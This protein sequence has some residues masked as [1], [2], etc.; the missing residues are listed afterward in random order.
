[1]E[2]TEGIERS[3]LFLIIIQFVGAFLSLL[4]GATLV[5]H[6]DPL[7]ECVLFAWQEGDSL[8]YGEPHYCD[9]IGYGFILNNVLVIV[10][11]YLTLRQ[12]SN[13]SSLSKHFSMR[14]L[15]SLKIGKRL[16]I[17]HGIVLSIVFIL[18]VFLTVGY[19]SSCDQLEDHITKL[20]NVKLNQDPNL[21]RGETIEERFVED[22]MFWRY[23][24]QVT[25]AFG[26][27]MY[28]IK[29][30]C[31]ALFTD[32][33]IATLLHDNHVKKYSGY[34]GWWYHQDIYSYDA[35]AQAVRTNVLIE[36]SLAGAWMGTFVWLGATIFIFVQKKRIAKQTSLA[37]SG[38]VDTMSTRSDR[39]GSTLQRGSL[40]PGQSPASSIRL[41]GNVY[42]S[43][44]SNASSYNRKDI[45][46]LALG[47]ILDP[48]FYKNN[49]NNNTVKMA[50]SNRRR[51]GSLGHLQMQ[52]Q[53]QPLLINNRP[54]AGR[55]QYETEI[56]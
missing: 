29:A 11:A 36:A 55:E 46:E 7:S 51:S 15:K 21:L 23:A 2:N 24:Q 8:S 27:N 53:S 54:T 22:P 33:D 17:L 16:I 49:R 25:N 1:M 52:I 9:I 6:V 20:L 34:F 31:R 13:I 40:R 14:N 42:A 28:N 44:T 45:D 3:L 26:S 56:M 30:S 5:A 39:S 4:A 10:T 35:Q 19:K 37:R 12:R 48:N 47:S 50:K 32:P 18:T 43:V 41:T 38:A